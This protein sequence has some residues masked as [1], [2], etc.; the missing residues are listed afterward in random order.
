MK[1]MAAARKEFQP[2]DEPFRKESLDINRI[3]MPMTGLVRL[4]TLRHGIK[5]NSTT[6]RLTSLYESN[7]PDLVVMRDML[8]A[9]IDIL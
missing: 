1:I 9:L 7:H 4:N 3:M 5:D 6:G 2:S 8:N